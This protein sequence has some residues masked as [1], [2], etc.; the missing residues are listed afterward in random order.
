MKVM[1][2]INI[3]PAISLAIPSTLLRLKSP[4]DIGVDENSNKIRKIFEKTSSINVLLKNYEQPEGMINMLENIFGEK[5]NKSFV[6]FSFPSETRRRE[7]LDECGVFLSNPNLKVAYLERVYQKSYASLNPEKG[8]KFE[9]EFEHEPD[10]LAIQNPAASIQVQEKF[11]KGL[12]KWRKFH[13]SGH[14]IFSTLYALEFHIGCLI[15]RSGTFLF[16]IDNLI[17]VTRK[18]YLDMIE[19]TFRKAWTNNAN[20]KL[21][22]LI[23]KEIFTFNPFEWNNDDKNYGLIEIFNEKNILLDEN[24][25]DLNGYPLNIEMFWSVFSVSTDNFKTLNFNNYRGPDSDVAKMIVERMNATSKLKQ[26]M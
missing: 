6:V 18:Y 17:N 7:W 24:V 21:H 25:K 19:S 10:P 4:L 14:I 9:E 20:L 23:N 3:F 15:N 13:Y 12:D 8:L 16:I 5:A 22:I 26:L 11:A 2:W 1:I